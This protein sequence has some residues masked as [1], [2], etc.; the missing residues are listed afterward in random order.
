MG[1]LIHVLSANRS[2]T[3]FPSWPAAR[4]FFLFSGIN[5]SIDQRCHTTTTLP[6]LSSATHT[7]SID[8]DTPFAA[9]AAAAEDGDV[10]AVRS[11][12]VRP[13]LTGPRQ[14]TYAKWTKAE[15]DELVRLRK[16]GITDPD[17]ATHLGRTYDSVKN[18]ISKKLL[19]RPESKLERYHRKTSIP[20]SIEEDRQILTL[21][22]ADV[23]GSKIAASLNRDTHSVM[24]RY[25]RAL[26]PKVTNTANASLSKAPWTDQDDDLL[27]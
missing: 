1:L 12:P 4:K 22:A 6:C 8:L 5:V 24:T 17:M 25:L 21:H 14:R 11:V 2:L 16:A 20:F 18:H 19:H 26:S 27:R 13:L 10:N 23:P 15:E 9:P 7:I 3:R